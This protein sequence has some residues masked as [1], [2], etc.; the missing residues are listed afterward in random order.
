MRE[1][2]TDLENLAIFTFAHDLRQPLRA[3]LLQS[4]TLLRRETF[5]AGVVAEALNGIIDAARLQDSLIASVVEYSDADPGASGTSSQSLALAVE[6]ALMRVESIRAASG[7]RIS[8]PHLPGA[9][10]SPAVGTILEKL[11]GNALKFYPAGSHP[12]VS[13]SAEMDGEYVLLSVTDAGIGVP[14]EYRLQVFEPFKRL[15]PASAYPGHGMGLAIS[16]RL[17]ECIEGQ[18]EIVDPPLGVGTRLVL[19]APV[20]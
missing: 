14:S 15:H 19:R 20:H 13:V 9:Q 10:V 8:V 18:I 16:R 6:G 17:T 2:R 4:Q 12:D 7:G 11:L 3:I 5:D 1:A